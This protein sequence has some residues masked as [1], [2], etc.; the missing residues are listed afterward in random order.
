MQSVKHSS[1]QLNYF[2]ECVVWVCRMNCPLVDKF[3][4]PITRALPGLLFPRPFGVT[5]YQEPEPEDYFDHV[6]ID[7]LLG[8]L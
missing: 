1:H 5:R 8:Q 6:L 3:V 4:T 2:H 7:I